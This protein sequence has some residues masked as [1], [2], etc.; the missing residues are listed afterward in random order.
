MFIC[1]DPPFIFIHIPRTSGIGLYDALKRC[2]CRPWRMPGL[3]MHA[4]ISDILARLPAWFVQRAYRFSIVRNPWERILSRFLYLRRQQS[5]MRSEGWIP[6]PGHRSFKEWLL[7]RERG[8][9]HPLDLRPQTAFLG[10]EQCHTVVRYERLEEGM[11]PL[12][13]E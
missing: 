13:P 10:E 1:K 3:Y 5:R 6:L 9:I 8:C 7:C 4:G 2:G 11:V 12:I